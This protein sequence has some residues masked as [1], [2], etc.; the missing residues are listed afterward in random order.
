MRVAAYSRCEWRTVWSYG[1]LSDE[2][3]QE[4]RCCLVD[5]REVVRVDRDDCRRSDGDDCDFR[6]HENP[7]YP[8]YWHARGYGLFAANPLGQK[9]FDPKAAAIGLH[10]REGSECDVSVSDHRSWIAR[11]QPDEMNKARRVRGCLQ[12]SSGS[13]R[14]EEWES[15]SMIEAASLIALIA[16][17]PSRLRVTAEDLVEGRR[18]CVHRLLEGGLE[19]LHLRRQADGDAD[20]GAASRPAA[21]DVDA[22]LRHESHESA[23]RD[24]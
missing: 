24:A 23:G 15:A 8:T 17:R 14:T 13:L 2:R 11:L 22:V 6:S 7:G 16:K 1:R 21:A 4:G 3:G 12:V 10:D 20:V 18:R 9:I 19:G 5:T